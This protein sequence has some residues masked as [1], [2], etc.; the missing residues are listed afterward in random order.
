MLLFK[1]DLHRVFDVFS[2]CEHPASI[3]INISPPAKSTLSSWVYQT[4]K[5]KTFLTKS[6]AVGLTSINIEVYTM[7][8]IRWHV[9]TYVCGK[10]AGVCTVCSLQN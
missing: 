9:N 2:G 1:I 5:V 10:S 4:D 3:D 6:E 8:H 7:W